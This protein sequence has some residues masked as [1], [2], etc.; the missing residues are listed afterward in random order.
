MCKEYWRF[1][2]SQQMPSEQ[3]F[4]QIYYRC[5]SIA[6][7]NSSAACCVQ[8]LLRQCRTVGQMIPRVFHSEMDPSNQKKSL[9]VK[10][11][12]RTGWCVWNVDATHLLFQIMGWRYETKST[13]ITTNRPIGPIAQ[14]GLVLGD[15]MTATA[16]STVWCIPALPLQSMATA[17]GWKNTS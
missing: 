11:G 3:T 10:P 16:I 14:L 5:S 1:F 2:A 8:F 15:P 17:T 9:V 13:I 12:H 6:F 4:L 7:T